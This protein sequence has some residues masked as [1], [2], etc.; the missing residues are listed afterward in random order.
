MRMHLKPPPPHHP[1]ITGPPHTCVCFQTTGPPVR[2]I[3]QIEETQRKGHSLFSS[4]H[5]LINYSSKN[6]LPELS[7]LHILSRLT[8]WN[9]NKHW[10]L[11]R[12][13]QEEFLY[14]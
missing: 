14:R 6:G 5:L 11:E 10:I 1:S 4:D 12:E 9:F 7:R 13:C 2:N 3:T 8:S